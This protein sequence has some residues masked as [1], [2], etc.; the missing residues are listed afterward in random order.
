MRIKVTRLKFEPRALDDR[1]L[2]AV[3]QEKRFGPDLTR[4]DPMDADGFEQFGP[5]R[6]RGTTRDVA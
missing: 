4:R 5:T 1:A 2:V 6:H 3:T